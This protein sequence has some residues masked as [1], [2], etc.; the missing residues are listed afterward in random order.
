MD[1]SPLEHAIGEVTPDKSTYTSNCWALHPEQ[2]ELKSGVR[3][4]DAECHACGQLGEV[5]ATYKIDHGAAIPV[6]VHFEP[7]QEQ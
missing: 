4:I 7:E 1:F 3:K 5:Y 6:S 2:S